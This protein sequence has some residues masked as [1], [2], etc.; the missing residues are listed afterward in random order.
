MDKT[1]HWR[2]LWKMENLLRTMNPLEMQ[3][4]VYVETI[5]LVNWFLVRFP[6]NFVLNRLYSNRWQE[7]FDPSFQCY[8]HTAQQQQP[9]LIE[10]LSCF[11]HSQ[12]YPWFDFTAQL[13]AITLSAHTNWL[14]RLSLNKWSN[15]QRR[16]RRIF[17]FNNYLNM[18][19]NQL[20]LSHD[21]RVKHRKRSHN[22]CVYISR[23]TAKCTDFSHIF[24][25]R[26][27]IEYRPPS[28]DTKSSVV[29]LCDAISRLVYIPH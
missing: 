12:C 9:K 11:E 19:K 16:P 27:T 1:A 3:H 8:T 13:T 17:G 22:N 25:Y 6:L 20:T 10:W 24:M 18:N 21:A 26:V 7:Y 4:N 29:C 14:F 28:W 23:F 15:Q 2:W 5:L